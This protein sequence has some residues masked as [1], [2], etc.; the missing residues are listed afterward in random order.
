MG[1]PAPRP[2]ACPTCGSG[3]VR[4]RGV[5]IW[6]EPC[7]D[8]WHEGVEARVTQP[9]T[10]REVMIQRLEAVTKR[11]GVTVAPGVW[12]DDIDAIEREAR[13]DMPPEPPTW[14][15]VDE[16]PKAWGRRWNDGLREAG[17]PEPPTLDLLQAV[18]DTLAVE[19][20]HVVNEVSGYPID[21]QAFA[22]KLERALGAS[23]PPPD[24][25]DIAMG[26]AGWRVYEPGRASGMPNDATLADYG[27]R[28]RAA[29]GRATPEEPS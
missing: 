6:F 2:D 1:E 9:T 27:R 24:L 29:L 4:Y 5:G 28:L 3:D 21:E 14:E 19:G 26:L 15:G 16:P 8:E 20:W 13:A 7:G 25:S 18:A 11:H 10:A 17:P 22:G 12:L 23:P